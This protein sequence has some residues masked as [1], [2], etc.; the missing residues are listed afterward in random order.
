MDQDKNSNFFRKRTWPFFYLDKAESVCHMGVAE[1]KKFGAGGNGDAGGIIVHE[2]P[3]GK[4]L[5]IAIK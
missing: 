4:K 5:L 1:T 2:V 3:I